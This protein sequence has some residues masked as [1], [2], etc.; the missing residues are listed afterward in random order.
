MKTPVD[1]ITRSTPR[2]PHGIS[3]GSLCEVIFISL[4]STKTEFPSTVIFPGNLPSVE[5]YLR[6]WADV[7]TSVSS[8]IA[9]ISIGSFFLIIC[10]SAPSGAL[11]ARSCKTLM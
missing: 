7:L 10:A 9:T 2:S 4:P 6:R 11:P 8:L 5:S 3:A 1:S